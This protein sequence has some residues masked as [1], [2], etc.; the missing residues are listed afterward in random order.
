MATSSGGNPGASEINGSP[1]T[2]PLDTIDEMRS[3]AKWMLAAAGA[4]GAVLISGGPLVAIGQVRGA[5]DITLAVLGLAFAIGGVGVAIWYTSD[6]LVPKLTTPRTF[7]SAKELADLRRDINA[8]PE[9]F[10]GVAA[11][12][13]DGAPDTP[14]DRLF[15]RQ[16]ALRQNAASLVRQAAAEKDP[17]RREQYQ[18]QLRRVEESGERV[19]T[20]VQYVL[21]LGAA[22]RIKAALQLARRMTMA[23]AALVIIGAALFFIA[24]A[25]KGP[26]YVPVVTTRPTPTA[27][28]TP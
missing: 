11:P 13:R 19:G 26:T 12:P 25:S 23:G 3:A 28:A 14:L 10:L 2:S 8:E 21:A 16:Q 22:W 24:T 27:T 18:A 17:H 9:E 7:R 6:V 5:L 4:V 20:Y 15:E 1:G